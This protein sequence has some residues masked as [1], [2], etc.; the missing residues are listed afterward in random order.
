MFAGAYGI[1][2]LPDE[3][4]GLGGRGFPGAVGAAGTF[5]CGYP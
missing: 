4:T 1:D 5:G 2:F 3:L